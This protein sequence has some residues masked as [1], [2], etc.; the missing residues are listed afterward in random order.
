M[1]LVF[2]TN[3]DFVLFFRVRL[4]CWSI[5]QIT[6]IHLQEIA[7]LKVAITAKGLSRAV[8]ILYFHY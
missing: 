6:S 8:L 1:Q 7:Y 2:V 5:A 4:L 3:Y